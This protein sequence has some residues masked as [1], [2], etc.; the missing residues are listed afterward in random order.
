MAMTLEELSD[1]EEIRQVIYRWFRGLDRLDLDL[2]HASF[3][4]DGEFDGGPNTGPSAEFIPAMFGENGRVRKMF[5]MTSHYMMNLLI[6]WR[7]RHAITETY[8]VAYHRLAKGREAIEKA[9]GTTRFAELGGDADREYQFIL[10][11]RYAD[12]FEKRGGVWKIARKKLILEWSSVAPYAGLPDGEG[13]HSY[14]RLRGQRGAA[15]ESYRW[16]DA[17]V[18]GSPGALPVDHAA[19]ARQ[20]PHDD[21]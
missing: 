20:T 21:N 17:L 11:L 4:A 18:E 19:C 9:I 5:A 10:G 14:A 1:R 2:L 15:D 7:G 13:V 12:R 6:D 8:A 16:L 3:W